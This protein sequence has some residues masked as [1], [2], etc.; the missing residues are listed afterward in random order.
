MG[1]NKTTPWQCDDCHLA[2]GD[3][4]G[5]YF[6][7]GN[8]TDLFRVSEHFING[9]DLKAGSNQPTAVTSCLGCHNKSEMLI[10]ANDPDFGTFA[11]TDGDGVVG[12][13]SSF[14]HYGKNRSSDLR[15]TR[16]SSD[17]G[18]SADTNCSAWNSFPAN[19]NYTY[20]DC[21][22]CHQ[23]ASTAFAS[24]MNLSTGLGNHTQMLNHTDNANGPFC[25]DCH[26]QYDGNTTIRIHDLQLVKP[27]RSYSGPD[28]TGMY[29]STLCVSCHELKEVHADDASINSDSLECA[30]CHANA[31]GYAT[32]Y[33][34]KQVHGIRFINDSGVYS[35]A[36]NRTAAANCTT[37]HMNT[38][39]TGINAS[40]SAGVVSIPKVPT[41][42]GV[43]NHSNNESAGALWNQTGS[44]YFGP[45]KPESNNLRACLYC[46]GNVNNVS[47]NISDITDIVHNSTSLGRA[48]VAFSGANLVNGSINSTSEWCATCHS[49]NNS[50]RS[51]MVTQFS[52]AGFDEPPE[53]TE[54][55][56]G[57][58][59]FFNHSAIVN[60]G[61]ISDAKCQQ[62]HGG[63]LSGAAKMDEFLHNVDQGQLGQACTSCHA[64]END[65]NS[66]LAPRHINRT[67]FKLGVHANVN[68]N[69]TNTSTLNDS[70]D[71]AC[72][73]CHQ[74]DGSAP[75]FYSMG[76]IFDTPRT[77]FDCH[78]GTAAFQ[79]V[80][81]A[82]TVSEHFTNSSDIR[83][84]YNQTS[85]VLSCIGCHEL[86]EMLLPGRNDPDNGSTVT[87]VDGD[88]D[89]GGNQSFYHYGR[90]R[91]VELRKLYNSSGCGN[92][93]GS[94]TSTV[95]GISGMLST[96]NYTYTDCN[97]CH[98]N[99]S[100][101]FLSA[102]NFSGAGENSHEDMLNHTDELGG[103]FCLDCHYNASET[104]QARIHDAGIF[105]PAR[106]YNASADGAGMYDSANVC[107]QCHNDKEVHADDPS[108]NTDKLECASCHA[109]ASGYVAS[110]E[111]VYGVK[112]IHGIRFVNDSGVYSAAWN[113]T[114]AA[115][116]TT[117]HQGALISQI[118]ANASE[119]LSIP[120]IPV[121]FNHSDDA[122]AG[123]K[124][125]ETSGGYNGPWNVN[126]AGDNLPACLYCHG[127][128]P[129]ASTD[130]NNITNIVHN[131][132]A[133][134]RVDNAHQGSNIVNGTINS[135]SMWCGSCHYPNN[136][137][138]V[139]TTGG[140]A[141][142]GW[143]VPPDNTNEASTGFFNHSGSLLEDPPL[144]ASDAK[145]ALA[146]CHGSLLSG[147]AKMDEF[148]HNVMVGDLEDCIL[149]HDAS[150][151]LVP[152]AVV[153][154]SAWNSTGVDP[155]QNP[156]KKSENRTLHGD[157]NEDGVSNNSDC[158]ICHYNVTGMGGGY[159]VR[160][161]NGTGSADPNNV[162]EAN[163]YYCSVCHFVNT[164]STG[165]VLADSNVTNVGD[166]PKVN[167]HTPYSTVRTYSDLGL[168]FNGFAYFQPGRTPVCESCHLNSIFY[169]NAS[170]SDLKTVVHYG[171]YT[172][173]TTLGTSDQNT[174]NCDECHRGEAAV[175]P[176]TT[177]SS[178]RLTW[179]VNDS[180]GRSG[181]YL[182]GDAGNTA[183]GFDMFRTSDT[184]SRNYCWSCHLAQNENKIPSDPIEPPGSHFHSPQID[185]FMWN[186]QSCH[187]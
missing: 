26:I 168:S 9:S 83:A 151:G 138:Y 105:K 43:F 76:D 66:L 124:W 147:S 89:K 61:D 182:S 165:T 52:V 7:T 180:E 35:A 125:N 143:E 128:V 4:Y 132:T 63:L 141:S 49:N 54:N 116:C 38:L 17:C 29:N 2:S 13:N 115:N 96:T 81:N 60:S 161:Y 175:G 150:Q 78:N 146:G 53:F 133:L 158:Q 84:G 123:E 118:N 46:H 91:S 145:C 3:N 32:G 42:T 88:G 21:S 20:T 97:Y 23:N 137:Y 27:F 87:D 95:C 39:I 127:N 92:S 1:L 16:N 119:V 149:C 15:V 111:T 62:C 72:W 12:G 177:N 64:I 176:S 169:S 93:S 44:G 166:P 70:V 171:K 82:P 22:Y 68:S 102:M 173:L 163:T 108:I 179:G 45:W 122:L 107:L 184:T 90:N 129:K 160:L 37:C 187:G 55:L 159:V 33:G 18:G 25:T 73:A 59:V 135:T 134:G 181:G 140:F 67:A 130:P 164:T 144:A 77:C 19:T 6:N 71:K 58:T 80:S 74:S 50:L 30:S 104:T 139:A 117:C 112:Q 110:G 136:T 183:T 34:D 174:T 172:N 65:P 57:Q 31:S 69:A 113:G 10:P 36:W 48:A 148:A 11:D 154:V 152:T 162:S 47:T 131:A 126:G 8:Q 86:E 56:V 114:F 24:A 41:T 101:A 120:K 28:G 99:T 186:C 75:P 79:N 153:N 121:R 5:N 167:M 109:N 94:G 98:Q 103:P 40:P 51:A 14:Y 157:I 106:S 85:V 155:G 142:A 156:T 100:T 178:E 170:D 185:N